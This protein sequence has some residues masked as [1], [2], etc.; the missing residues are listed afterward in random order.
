MWLKYVR[1]WRYQYDVGKARAVAQ[2]FSAAHADFVRSNAIFYTALIQVVL[3]QTE[4]M[5]LTF[6]SRMC[7]V[8]A[9]P[10]LRLLRLLLFAPWLHSPFAH[11]APAS[12]DS[13]PGPQLA[14]QSQPACAPCSPGDAAGRH[15]QRGGG[16]PTGR[17]GR[18]Q[19][20]ERALR[21][22]MGTGVGCSREAAA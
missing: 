16:S 7:V 17:A 20:A 14:C 5:D 22:Y 9:V 3:S 15:L 1:P 13:R 2:P 12:A 6:D 10:L 21:R 4:Y 11:A 18:Q 8:C 19:F